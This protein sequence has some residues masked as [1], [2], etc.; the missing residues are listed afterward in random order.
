MKDLLTA[1]KAQLQTALAGVRDR[2]VFITED[3]NLV[4]AKVKFPAVGIKD[5]TVTRKRVST[6]LWERTSLVSI[7][8][9]V[10]LT[11]EEAAVMGSAGS[12]GVLDLAAAIRATLDDNLL[13]ITGMQDAECYSEQASATFGDEKMA[14][15]R[16][17]IIY[18][19]TQDE[20]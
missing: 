8:P 17:V 6:D 9:W 11:K 18:T 3:E 12:P 16:K 15:Q 7:I 1:I 13:G 20:G 2:D 19:Y 5:G 10:K 14:L 4:P